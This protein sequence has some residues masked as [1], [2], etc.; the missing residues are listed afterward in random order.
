M[1]VG[2]RVLFVTLLSGLPLHGQTTLDRSSLLSGGWVGTPGSLQVNTSF[3]FSGTDM[4]GRDVFVVPTVQLALGLP[5]WTLLGAQ[6]SPQS[7][8]AG[9]GIGEWEVF[10]RYKPLVQYRGA[11]LD[12]AVQAGFNGAAG[13]VDGEA[14]VARWFGPIRLLGAGRVFTDAYDSGDTRGALAGGA[15]FF[16]MPRK[17]PIALTGDAATLLDR[18]DGD[19]VAWSAGLQ[20]GIPF[21]VNTVS[22]FATNTGSGSLQ[23][24]SRGAGRTRFGLELTLP[25]PAGR[26]LGWYV[27]R[28]EAMEAVRDP[29]IP[30]SRVVSAEMFRYLFVEDR[31]EIPAGTTI[32]WTNHDAVVHTV[33]ADDASWNSG[34]IQPGARWSATYSEPG[35]Y[36]FHCGPHPFMKGTVIVR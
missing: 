1:G 18:N 28:E 25:I 33:A 14:A 9:G 2:M 29:P 19:E 22:L 16:P 4:P 21:T 3:R 31:I 13:S 27:S 26:F 5:A 8:V 7:Q 6:Y 20:V 10:G 15:V 36:P 11:P 35:T 23:G 32:E 30:E 24:I 17:M 12:L 34:A